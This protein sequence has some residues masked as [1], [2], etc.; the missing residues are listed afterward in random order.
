LLSHGA[1]L[2]I[3]AALAFSLM[4]VFVKAAGQ[5]LPSQEVVLARALV[6]LVLTWMLLRARR[7][8][9]WGTHRFLLFLRGLLGGLALACVFYSVTVLP[10]ADATVLQYLYPT[11]TALLAAV[12]LG[13]RAGRGALLASVVS[14]AGVLLVAKPSIIFGSASAPLEPLHV[15]IAVC[16]AVLT[17]L[18]YIDVKRLAAL[19][20]PLVIVFWFPLITVPLTIP[21]LL[22]TFVWPQ[23]MEWVW[24]LG[25]GVCTQAG[26]VL[27]TRGLLYE[28]ATR[29]TALTYLQVVFAA[30]WGALFF[31]E[32]PDVLT[33]VGAMLVVS[34]AVWL[35]WQGRSASAP[36]SP[37]AEA[38]PI[39]V[40]EEAEDL[41]TGSAASD[42]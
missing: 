31:G 2:I 25:V 13:E 29:A 18:A 20:D 4:T 5:R 32:V 14:L 41:V 30:L 22:D 9:P 24:L 21:T 11:F 34:G 17:A 28:S 26:Q 38:L 39:E 10:L 1:L 16:G 42:G 40:I 3:G 36:P 15:A 35:A 27:F 37:D 23:G 6:S 19:E 33:G 7:M 8:S 12:V